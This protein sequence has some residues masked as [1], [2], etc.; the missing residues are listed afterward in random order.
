[1]EHSD[2]GDGACGAGGWRVV[3]G[4][5]FNPVHIGHETIARRLCGAEGV[6]QV[7]VVPSGLSP[8]RAPRPGSV[9]AL[10]PW[11]LRHDMVRQALLD[12]GAPEGCALTVSDVERPAA[13]GSPNYTWETLQRL[14]ASAP[15]E[16]AQPPR[17]A[18]VV[19]ADQARHLHKWR[20]AE[21]ILSAVAVWVVQRP[22]DGSGTGLLA[23]SA[24]QR[25]EAQATWEN[26]AS[27]L[28]SPQPEL[29]WQG[30]EARGLRAAVGGAGSPE[31]AIEAFRWLGWGVAPISSS[32][33]R[34]G[35]LGAE[36]VAGGARALWDEWQ[37]AKP[38]P[39]VDRPLPGPAGATAAGGD[40]AVALSE[41][42]EA[43][44]FSAARWRQE[45]RASG[46]EEEGEVLRVVTWNVW[47]GE[48]EAERRWSA[49]LAE[50]LSLRPDVLFLQ[51]VTVRP[52]LAS[53]LPSCP[54]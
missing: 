47:F 6:E 13:D 7:I 49:L 34:R 25:E 15:A 9:D 36:V 35:Q 54:T 30:Q 17:W 50:A 18:L 20:D 4:G 52:A 11:E 28:D 22:Q 37:L 2:G 1:M 42:L 48:L 12:G 32:A 8:G 24:A 40:P 39:W 5:S 45:E 38:L 31:G 26:I 33:I 51:E 21:A 41:H 29:V 46:Q 53:G 16:E 43:N 10:L 14:I 23:D 3:Y 27:A 44:V 19:G